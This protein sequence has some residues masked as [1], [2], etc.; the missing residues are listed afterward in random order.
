VRAELKR[1]HS[2]DVPEE[3]EIFAPSS[4][5]GFR[6]F[7]EAEIGPSG[8][9][10]GDI[11]GFLVVGPDWFGENPPGKGWRWGRHY[12]VVDRW[13]YQ[14]VHRII[15][16]LCLHTEA[17]DWAGIARRLASFGSWEFDGYSHD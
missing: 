17:D 1:L 15:G 13:S 10:G 6:I 5:R 9:P 16:D 7:I 4:P 11:F 3:L 2:P 12:L 8:A 14:L